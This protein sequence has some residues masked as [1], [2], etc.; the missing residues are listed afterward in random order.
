MLVW[1]GFYNQA[2]HLDQR[3]GALASEVQAASGECG[4]DLAGAY[5]PGGA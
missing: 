3:L 4:A 1:S 5:M 2:S